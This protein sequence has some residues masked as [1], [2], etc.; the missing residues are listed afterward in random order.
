MK[1]INSNKNNNNNQN[2]SNNRVE[3]EPEMNPQRSMKFGRNV[4]GDD[5][6]T[7]SKQKNQTSWW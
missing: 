3:Q 2:N 7:S 1:S 4:Q 6:S 5:G